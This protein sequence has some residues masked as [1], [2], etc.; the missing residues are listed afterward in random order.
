MIDKLNHIKKLVVLVGGTN[1]GKSTTLQYMANCTMHTLG[2]SRKAN[3]YPWEVV[4]AGGMFPFSAKPRSDNQYVLEKSVED[5]SVKVG[6]STYG[7]N[8]SWVDYGFNWFEQN[9][10]GIGVI[11]SKTRG[12][13]LNQIESV[14]SRSGIKPIYVYLP[15][16]DAVGVS[17]R[18]QT[19]IEIDTADY[20]VKI[21]ERV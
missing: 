7:D 2:Y 14:S 11:A 17:L 3:L 13:A 20:I 1:S 21:L 18:S 8:D 16:S 12:T 10:C 9:Q 19:D 6:V 4:P 15:P 5:K